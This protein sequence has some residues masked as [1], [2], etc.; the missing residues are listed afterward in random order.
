MWSQRGQASL[1]WVAVVALVA[2]VFGALAIPVATGT[3]I[4]RRVTR[5]F[6][7]AMCTVA[8]GECEHDREPCVLTSRGERGEAGVNIAIVKLGQGYVAL[9]ERRSDGQV[10]VTRTKL[11]EVGVEGALIGVEAG[12]SWGNTQ[13]SVGAE[14][15]A[16]ALARGG[17]GATW[18]V[19]ATE[20]DAMLRSFHTEAA[21]RLAGPLPGLLVSKKADSALPE[22][23]A[24]F[25]ESG[26]STSLGAAASAGGAGAS[27][28]ASA[29]LTAANTLG[30]RLDRA[31]GRRTIYLHGGAAA[32]ASLGLAGNELTG[33]ERSG[34]DTSWSLVVDRDGSPRTLTLTESGPYR[35][36][37]DLPAD[38]QEVA[39]R[40]AVSTRGDRAY[41]V[42]RRLDLT[43]DA[44]RAAVMPFVRHLTSA[45]AHALPPEQSALLRERLR[46]ATVEARV[47]EVGDARSYGGS[48]HGAFGGIKVGGGGEYSV[49]E[50]RLVAA[51]SRGLDGQWLGRADCL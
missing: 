23:S 36:S 8:G 2:V 28:E 17:P 14:I 19:P 22:P 46:S 35:V 9:V 44:T 42:E 34:P 45:K 25:N 37:A 51:Q 16:S 21:G 6:V 18:I 32:S 11:A 13:L 49:T 10:A 15:Q 30:S 24:T 1:E 31:T 27:L 33:A 29:K 26:W 5:E 39:G 47:H 3:D 41:S 40:L 50:S 20:V 48:L 38:V 4:S 43:D 7:R 12:G